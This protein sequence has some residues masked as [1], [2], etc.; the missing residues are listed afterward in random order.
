MAEEPSKFQEPEKDSAKIPASHS[1]QSRYSRVAENESIAKWI[2]RKE[3][4]RSKSVQPGMP[5]RTGLVSRKGLNPISKKQQKKLNDY[6]KARDAHYK[7]ESNRV[8]LLCGGTNNLSVHHSKKR[9]ESI[10]DTKTFFTLCLKGRY[11]DEL[12]PDANHNHTGGC[13]GFVEANPSIAREL[14]VTV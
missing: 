6:K 8:C 1:G 12:Y 13:H 10:A 11:L 7:E 5:R 9:G 4:K 3:E 14:G 2:A